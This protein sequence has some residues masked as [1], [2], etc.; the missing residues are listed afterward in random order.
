MKKTKKKRKL[1]KIR[2]LFLLFFI[3]G[4]SFAFIKL[5]NVR[6][7]SIKIKGNKILTD[8][9]VIE[10]AKLEDYP[11]FFETLSY[12]I[13]KRLLKNNYIDINCEDFEKMW[14]MHPE[15]DID[16]CIMPIATLLEKTQEMNKNLYF[17]ALDKNIIPSLEQIE[18]LTAIEDILMIGY[19]NGL[20]DSYN[21]MPIIRRGVTATNLK[22]DY[23]NKKEFLIDIVAFPGSS[24]SP[25]FI[26]NRG[27]YPV[28]DG[29]AIGDRL[30]LV[31][32][33]FAGTQMNIEGNIEIVEV[34]TINIPISKSKIPNNIGIIIKIEKLLNFELILK[35][36]LNSK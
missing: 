25:V 1:K 13:K 18:K 26:Y 2:F 5:F 3:V 34:P 10:T 8:Q 21:N 35:E 19:P 9:E 24:G 28:N 22:L 12:T 14:I 32:V 30:L 36:K 6:I 23:N 31:G 15:E 29:I 7:Y 4:I 17:K 20:W 27:S 16:L 33:L 11:S